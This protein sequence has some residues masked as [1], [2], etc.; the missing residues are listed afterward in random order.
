MWKDRTLFFHPSLHQ[1]YERPESQTYSTSPSA[2][3]QLAGLSLVKWFIENEFVDE[4]SATTAGT[5][6]GYFFSLHF[7]PDQKKVSFSQKP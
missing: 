5:C 1:R 4:E 6:C 2:F 3:I 7:S